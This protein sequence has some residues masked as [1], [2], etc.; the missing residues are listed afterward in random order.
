VG[1]QVC[2][3]GNAPKDGSR[4]GDVLT[5]S[6]KTRNGAS[7]IHDV[8][9]DPVCKCTRLLC[10]DECLT[11]QLLELSHSWAEGTAPCRGGCLALR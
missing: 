10:S 9:V 4:G 11:P 6:G 7:R 5:C 2:G 8:K 1:F 3:L